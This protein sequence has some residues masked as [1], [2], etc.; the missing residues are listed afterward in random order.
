MS[1][2]KPDKLVQ[3]ILGKPKKKKRP[4]FGPRQ[5]PGQKGFDQ[6]SRKKASNTIKEIEKII[7]KVLY[8]GEK[9]KLEPDIAKAL[10]KLEDAVL[11]ELLSSM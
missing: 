11:G 7:R 8:L 10:D 3:K 9:E 6:E 2:Y 5:V 1:K 4:G